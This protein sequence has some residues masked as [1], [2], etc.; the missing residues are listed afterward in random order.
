MTYSFEWMLGPAVLGIVLLPLVVPS[1]A[2][3][4]VMVMALAAVAALVALA[5][6]I[7][8]M[9]YLLVRSLRRRVSER[10]SKRPLGVA[11]RASR[12]GR[13]GGAATLGKP[14]SARRAK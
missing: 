13:S 6:A 14:A 5:G 3:I 1:F 12:T 8:A 7:F 9:P 2:L 4:G 11:R 10:A